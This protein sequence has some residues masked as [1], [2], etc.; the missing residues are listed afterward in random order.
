MTTNK[1]TDS[2]AK[3]CNVGLNLFSLQFLVLL[4]VVIFLM[5]DGGEDLTS[6]TNTS[7]NV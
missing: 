5:N 1:Y 2:S 3:K 7:C 4:K 6:V